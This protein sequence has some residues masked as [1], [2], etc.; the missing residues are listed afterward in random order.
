MSRPN[1]YPESRYDLGGRSGYSSFGEWLVPA[2][3]VAIIG[4]VIYGAWCFT[5]NG[6][7]CGTPRST[8][9]RVRSNMRS[10]ATAVETYYVEKGEHP[11]YAFSPDL[12][13]DGLSGA[14]LTGRATSTFR[15]DVAHLTTPIAYIDSYAGFTD[16][17][18]SVPGTP[19]RYQR[20]GNGWIIGSFGPDR[21]QATGGDL[22]WDRPLVMYDPAAMDPTRKL[23]PFSYDPTNGTVSEGDLWR[24][25]Q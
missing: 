16:P 12:T 4:V 23:L 3:R 8:A 21:D 22:H 6:L 18:A 10:L 7:D 24:V 20:R 9:S 5:D 19:L 13:A 14:K 17:Y 11:A 25:K 15:V 1:P 2:V